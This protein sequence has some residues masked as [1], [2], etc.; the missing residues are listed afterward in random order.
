ME[1]AS[2][3]YKWWFVK[4][5]NLN[6]TFALNAK[7]S[8]RILQIMKNLNSIKVASFKSIF[9]TTSNSEYKVVQADI[10]Y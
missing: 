3:Q 1:L 8:L 2:S 4:Y 6:P 7:T 9:D 5:A 10:I